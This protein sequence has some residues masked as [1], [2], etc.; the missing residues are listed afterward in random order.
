MQHATML[1]TQTEAKKNFKSS[2]LVLG[3]RWY[4][5]KESQSMY[6]FKTLYST[7]SLLKDLHLP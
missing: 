1:K 5:L 2:F 7:N 4:K 6:L 3:C